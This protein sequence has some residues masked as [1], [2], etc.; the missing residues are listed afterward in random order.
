MCGDI[1][2]HHTSWGSRHAN[3]RGTLLVDAITTCQLAPINT[4]ETTFVKRNNRQSCIDV[5]FTSE[6]CKYSW[7]PE[8]SSRCS[9]YKPIIITPQSTETQRERQFSVVHWNRFRELL[10][11]HQQDNFLEA[12]AHALKAATRAARV[13]PFQPATDLK[14][15][16]SVPQTTEPARRKIASATQGPSLR[17][18]GLMDGVQPNRRS[19]TPARKAALKGQLGIYLLLARERREL[20]SFSNSPWP[21]SPPSCPPP[22]KTPCPSASTPTTWQSGARRAPERTL[23]PARQRSLP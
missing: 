11:E 18:A 8:A 12:M 6:H 4:G 1:N 20:R 5:T 13:A 15:R 7:R 2:A 9:D 23:G 3:K 19:T 10:D 21:H 22:L 14:P 17:R 16:S